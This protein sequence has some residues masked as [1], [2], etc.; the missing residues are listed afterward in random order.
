M[1][2]DGLPAEV[3]NINLIGLRRDG[4]PDEEIRALKEAFRILYHDRA[5]NPMPIAE[6]LKLAEALVTPGD[7]TSPLARLVAWQRL[8]LEKNVRGRL[9][10]ADRQP[11]IGAKPT[12]KTEG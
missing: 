2:A 8:Y 4:V 9:A 12:P 11:I 3:R 7:T 10:E 6:S 1:M 5:N